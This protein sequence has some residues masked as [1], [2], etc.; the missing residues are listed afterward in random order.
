[1]LGLTLLACATL[2]TARFAF[3]E[4]RLNRVP[5]NDLVF[6]ITASEHLLSALENHRSVDSWVSE[7]SLGY[8]VWLSYQPL[9]HLAG[10]LVIKACRAFATPEASFAAF[11]YLLLLALPMSVYLG[12]RLMGLNPVAS[13]LASLLVF[14]SSATG[15]LGSYGLGYGAFAWSGSGLYTQLFALHFLAISWG[16]T[17]RALEIGRKNWLIGAGVLIALTTLSHIIFGYVAFAS[18]VVMAAA[19]PRPQWRQRLLRLLAIVFPALLLLAW[20]FV[21]LLLRLDVVNHSRWENPQKWDS[22]GAPFILREILSGRFFDSGRP[23]ILSLLIAAGI[24]TAAIHYR[25]QLAR[26]LL[27]LCGSALVLFFGRETWGH[28]VWLAGVPADLQMHRLQAAF[29]L[30]AV[31]LAALGL[32]QLVAWART[33]G[34]RFAL[35]MIAAIGVGVVWIGTDRAAFLKQNQVWGDENLAA[36]RT[37]HADLDAALADIRQIL[38]ERPG[39]VSAGLAASWGRQFTVGQVPVYAFLSRHHIDQVSFL[40][41]SMSKTSDVMVL[42]NESNPAHDVAFGIRAVI[43]PAT[44]AMPGYLQRRSVHGPFAVYE[45]SPEGY[46]GVVDIAGFYDGPPSTDFEPESAW[47]SSPLQNAGWVVSLDSRQRSLPKIHR[48]DPLPPP[49]ASSSF[50]GRVIAEEKSGEIYTAR[51]EV[52]RPAYAFVKITWNP[53]LEATVDGRPAPVFHVTPGFGA[54]PL[55][56]GRHQ[57]VVRYQPGPLRSVLLFLG[58]AA[59]AGV[60]FALR[61]PVGEPRE[62]NAAETA[63]SPRW[64]APLVVVLSAVVALHPLVRGRLIGGHDAASYPARVVEMGRILSDGQFPPMWAPDLSAGHGQPLFEFNPPL[65][66]WVAL[67]LRA[68]GLGLTDSLQLG[69]LVLFLAGSVAM[70]KTARLL[71]APRYAAL[72]G[73]IAWLFAPYVSLDLFVRS[74]FAESAA[75]AM[76]PVALW[77]LLAAIQ[78][79]G[80]GRIACASV[81]I[82]L[83]LLAH[84]AVALLLVPG[85]AAIALVYAR[86]RGIRSLMAGLGAIAAALGLSAFFWIPSLADISNLH[87]SRLLENGFEWQTHIL[88]PLQLL[89]GNWGYGVSVAGPGDGMSFNVGPVHIVLAVAGLLTL[90]H[91]TGDPR[92]NVAIVFAALALLGGFLAI[93]W[94]APIWRRAHLLHHLIYPWRSLFLPALFLPLLAIFEF[95]RLGKTPAILLTGVLVAL[96]LS[97]TEPQQYLSYDEEYYAPASI[98]AQGLNTTTH[99]EFEPRWSDQRPPYAASPLQ[100]ITGPIQVRELMRRSTRQEYSVYAQNDTRLESSISYYPGWTVY[101]DGKPVPLS[102]APAKGTIQFEI[103]RGEHRVVMELLLTPVRRLSLLVSLATSVFLALWLLTVRRSSARRGRINTVC[104]G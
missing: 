12:A 68:I 50:D 36:F 104:Q 37:S 86:R 54:V 4:T 81:A 2:F 89:W 74:A 98:A 72:G 24:C 27:I 10:A 85:L 94:S 55:A 53:D 99:E 42:R 14:A 9:P 44:Q 47:L 33:R 59:F 82:A 51:L 31:L 78:Q 52:N 73:A 75:V 80:A 41:H 62:I 3:P 1:M 23:P 93:E 66:Y 71:S 102:P 87:A 43:A 95:E 65:L 25:R 58:L 16:V 8:P 77:A 70:Y 88:S 49:P 21:P 15:N 22:Y 64:A 84:S 69:L 26:Q 63:M 90:I 57:V 100:G 6:H 30:S 38:A 79:P 5:L 83:V 45:A 18:A 97:H 67:P 28:L 7:W 48:W 19:A 13:G 17:T 29:E 76:A 56:G 91:A 46:F 40:Y 103:P 92:R 32:T 35:V 60:W 20:F 11:Y 101:L 96:N 61:D 39:R 34:T